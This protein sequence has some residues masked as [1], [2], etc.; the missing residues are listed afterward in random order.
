[1][2]CFQRQFLL[3]S[4]VYSF[5]STLPWVSVTSF[6][7]LL[8]SVMSQRLLCLL[9]FSCHHIPVSPPGG[10][11][12]TWS[13]PSPPEGV[14]SH[15]HTWLVAVINWL[16]KVQIAKHLV[17]EYLPGMVPLA[18]SGHLCHLRFFRCLLFVL[19]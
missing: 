3:E 10:A 17:P 6:H 15:L 16:H 14:L 18:L 1:M 11:T 5:Q 13:C 2:Y 8:V 7:V 9:C 12:R 19:F 4:K